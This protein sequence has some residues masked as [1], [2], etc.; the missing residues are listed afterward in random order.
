[1]KH[2]QLTAIAAVV[3]IRCGPSVDIWT[4]AG[5]KKIEAVKKHLAADTDVNAK[6]EWVWNPL[7]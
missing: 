5:K 3:L 7:Y 4:A 1:M 2:L 6:D